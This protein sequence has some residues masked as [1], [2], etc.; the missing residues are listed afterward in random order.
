M[1]RREFIAGL[2]SENTSSGLHSFRLGLHQL[3]VGRSPQH[4]D[5]VGGRHHLVQQFKALST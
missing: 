1:R 4:G 2:G 5:R 3:G